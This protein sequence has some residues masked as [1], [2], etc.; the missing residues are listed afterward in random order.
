MPPLVLALLGVAAV[1]H[2]TWNVLLKTSEDPLATAARA[3]TWGLLAATPL[4]GGVWLVSGRPAPSILAVGLAALSGAIE[5]LYFVFLS[6]AYRRG[7]L[8]TVYPIARGTA[9]ALAVGS[10]VLL[11]GERLAPAAWAGVALVLVGLW[12]ARGASG[13]GAAAGF[14][15]LTGI[16]IAAYSTVDRLG[17][18]AAPPWLYGWI[19]WVFTTAFL[20]LALVLRRRPTP[21]EVPRR[22]AVIG[23][24]MLGTWLLVLF[25]LSL[26]PLAVV[27]PIREA[28]MVLAAGWGV[29]RLGERSRLGL[30]LGG[31]GLI[32]AGVVLVAVA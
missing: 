3:V 6:A 10:G 8:S 15:V 20:R 29:L 17:V 30:R 31:A 18:L 13:S 14:A 4:L 32:A 21:A 28:A 16:A 23:V 25:A 1:S 22:D 11:L 12:L 26:A 24:L 19:L 2:T 9:P 27:A 5:L 7:D